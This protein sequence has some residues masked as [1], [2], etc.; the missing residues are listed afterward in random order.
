MQT[1]FLTVSEWVAAG[2]F[3]TG[4]YCLEKLVSETEKAFGF[5]AEKYN[6]AGNLKP[7][8]C[9]I[10]K[11]QVQIVRNDFYVTGPEKMFLLPAWLYLKKGDEGFI[12]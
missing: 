3:K 8:I 2:C 11:S 9:W 6:S 12:L 7:V 5:K 4:Q 1:N 10:P